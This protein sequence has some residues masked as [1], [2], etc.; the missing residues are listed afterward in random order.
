MSCPS[1]FVLTV[2]FCLAVSEVCLGHPSLPVLF[3]LSCFRLSCALF[4]P[5]CSGCHVPAGMFG[6]SYFGCSVP[7]VLSLAVQI[8]FRLSYIG[9]VPAVLCPA[10]FCLTV[11]DVMSCRDPTVLSLKWSEFRSLK[12][13]QIVWDDKKKS[14]SE[15]WSQCFHI[16]ILQIRNTSCKEFFA[17]SEGTLYFKK[18][19]CAWQCRKLF[20]TIGL[21]LF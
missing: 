10:V 9:V 4:R 21:I 7:V 18:D 1:Y 5:P 15:I 8:L 11:W 19:L 20:N 12:E 17:L 6:L 14:S 2:K 13:K 16:K 3:S